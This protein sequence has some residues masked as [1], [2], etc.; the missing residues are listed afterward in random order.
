MKIGVP[1][2]D[3][4][5][6]ISIS[7]YNISDSEETPQVIP[8]IVMTNARQGSSDTLMDE[9]EI[10]SNLSASEMQEFLRYIQQ[11]RENSILVASSSTITQQP[12][13]TQVLRRDL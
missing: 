3:S 9:H 5:S 6:N 4:S 7:Y 11:R 10:L 12:P 1:E 2:S 13:P 8:T